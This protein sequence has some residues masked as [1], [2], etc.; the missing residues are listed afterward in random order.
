V[1][2]N[3][4]DIDGPMLTIDEL[5]HAV[6]LPS[7][8]IRLYRTRGLLPPPRKRGREALY[9]EGHVA[10]ID[11]IGRLQDRGFSLAS[12]SELIE[13]WE[14]GRDLDDILGLERRVAATGQSARPLRLTPA[15]LAAQFPNIE[16]TPEVMTHVVKLGLVEIEDGV[17][18][19][20]NPVFLEVGT[21]LV[22]LGFPL[23]EVLDE[24]AILQAEMTQVAERFAGMFERN[25]W[26]PF[27][28]GGRPDDQL[29]KVNAALDRLGP[30]ADQVVH[31]ALDLALASTAARF[32]ADEAKR[33]TTAKSRKGRRGA[34]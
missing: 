30:L 16:I 17:V 23:S 6:G 3:E 32:V 21:A 7:S 28:E 1:T 26:R 15:Q 31:A 12:I 2:K 11:L 18:V 20:P 19:I 24:A 5:A 13:Q 25:I 27:V 10:R 22:A 4:A 34:R 9:G 29:A 33:G 8:T 14:D